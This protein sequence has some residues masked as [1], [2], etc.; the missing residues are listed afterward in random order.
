VAGAAADAADTVVLKKLQAATGLVFAVFVALHLLN[1]WL[2]ALGPGAYNGVQ[3]VLRGIYQ[4]PPV[5][6]LLLAALAVHVVVGVMRMLREP[7][8]VLS[9]RARLHRYAGFFLT[10]VIVGHILA[11][12][13]SSWFFDVYP[14]FAGLAFSVAA[15]PAYFYPYYFLLGV[16]GF[17]HA[18]NGSSIAAARLGWSLRLS[19][20]RLG[21]GTALAAVGMSAALL[22]F[23]G[24]LFEVADPWQS[25][26]AVLVLELVDE[27]TP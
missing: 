9:L 11:V 23:G 17:Y 12:R 3:A 21:M 16:A 10:L 18:A 7:R 8:R 20:R 14:G 25:E 13:G 27:R 6:A 15:V 24:W 4:F 19:N 2:A 5:E 1:T 22:G 26:F